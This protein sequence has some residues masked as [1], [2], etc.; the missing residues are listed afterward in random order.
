M[1][2]IF[3]CEN[4]IKTVYL[5]KTEFQHIIDSLNNLYSWLRHRLSYF[6]E[7]T[8]IDIFSF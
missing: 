6:F 2:K 4:V 7:V 1:D 3:C 8:G 5:V